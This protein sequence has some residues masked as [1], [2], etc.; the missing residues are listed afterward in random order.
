MAGFCRSRMV[1][2]WGTRNPFYLSSL[3]LFLLNEFD[4]RY[5]KQ[6]AQRAPGAS[7]GTQ[8][9]LLFFFLRNAP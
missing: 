7:V 5:S 6:Q 1:V 3:V 2:T 4:E 9:R 8:R